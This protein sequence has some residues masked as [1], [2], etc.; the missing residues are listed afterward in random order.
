MKFVWQP[1]IRRRDH[2]HRRHWRREESS[3]FAYLSCRLF[4][5]R[6]LRRRRLYRNT[7]LY[8]GPG[9]RDRDRNCKSLTAFTGAKRFSPTVTSRYENQQLGSIVTG[10][11][12]VTR[13]TD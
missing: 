12:R 2:R 3:G 13:T 1:G 10:P 6:L 7:R 11:V 9:V 8:Y 4:V 5:E